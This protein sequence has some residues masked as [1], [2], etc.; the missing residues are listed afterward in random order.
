[1]FEGF[2]EMQAVVTRVHEK[3]ALGGELSTASWN[4]VLSA[5]CIN[6]NKTDIIRAKSRS[7]LVASLFVKSGASKSS[8]QSGNLGKDML[9]RKGS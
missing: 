5:F 2:L 6:R 8:G 4:L 3:L 1:M 7:C 9:Q